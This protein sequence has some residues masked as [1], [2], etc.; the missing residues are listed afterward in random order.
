MIKKNLTKKLFSLT[1]ALL[2]IFSISVASTAATTIEDTYTQEGDSGVSTITLPGLYG[3][4]LMIYY[5]SD[6]SEGNYPLI[7]WGNGTFTNPTAYSELLTHV[8][9]YG[10]IIVCSYNSNQGTG[11]LMENAAD[12]MILQNSNPFSRFY[13]K[14][15]IENIAA[16]GHSQG[17][18]GAVNVANSASYIDTVIPMSL[19]A[20]DTLD[21]LGVSCDVTQL[22]VPTFLTSGVNETVVMAPPY[23]TAGYYNDMLSNNPNQPVVKASLNFAMHNEMTDDYGNPE[24]YFGYIT[25]WLMYQLKGDTTA[26]SA[27]VGSNPEISSNYSWLFVDINNIQ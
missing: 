11:I 3:D 9:S 6:M 25:A 1:M 10:F 13:N 20:E 16:M 7:T 8:A 4:M 17:A 27:F 5:P 19:V 21:T 26:A 2:M 12:Y 22:T 23:V 15:D 18:C 24:R 14:V